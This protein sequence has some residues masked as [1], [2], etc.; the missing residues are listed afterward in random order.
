MKHKICFITLFIVLSFGNIIQAQ[1]TEQKSISCP[2]S[3]DGSLAVFPSFGTAPYTYVWSTGSTENIIKGLGPGVYSVTVTD[4]LAVSNNYS[5][6]LSDPPAITAAYAIVPNSNWPTPNGRITINASGGSGWFTYQLIDSTTTEETTQTNNVFNNRFSGTYFVTITDV[7]GCERYDTV[8]VTETAGITTTF[9]I[10]YTACYRSTAP[11]SNVI[12]VLVPANLPTQVQFPEDTVTIVELLS[13]ARYRT[14]TSDTVTSFSYNAQ[15]GRNLFKVVT[16]DNKGFRYSWVVLE[17]SNPITLTFDEPRHVLC[18]GDNSGFIHG[19]NAQGSY[20]DFSYST[21]G[22]S[23]FSSTNQNLNNLY[24]GLYLVTTTDSSGDCSITLPVTILQSDAPLQGT[25]IKKD[26]TCYQSGNGSITG[27]FTGGTGQL[28]YLW[29]SGQTTSSIGGLTAGTYTLTVTDENGCTLTPPAVTINEPLELTVNGFIQQVSCYGYNNGRIQTTPIGGNGGYVYT[30][31][32]DGVLINYND[33]IIS[34]LSPGVYDLHLEDSLGCDYYNSWTVTQ[35]SNFQFEFVNTLISCNDELGTIRVHN[36]EAFPLDVTVEGITQTVV[37]DDTTGFSD[38]PIGDHL[39][40]I[41]NG[42]CTFDT[43]ITFTQPLPLVI[44][45]NP[46]PSLCYDGRGSVE[47]NV[48]GGTSGPNSTLVLD[49]TNYLNIDTTVTILTPANNFI[50][51]RLKAGSYD[52]TVTDD[53][54]CIVNDKVII[55]QPDRPRTFFSVEKTTCPE[56]EDGKALVT[57]VIPFQDPCT[58]LWNTTPIQTTQE[59]DSLA[60]GWYKVQVTDFNNCVVTD[61]VEVEAGNGVAI[62]NTITQNGDGLNDVIDVRNLCYNASSV[63]FVIQNRDNLTLFETTDPSEAIWNG[64]D[65]SGNVFSST[66]LV[67]L[68]LK[69]IRQDGSKREYWKTIT[70]IV[71]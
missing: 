28:S 20:G 8:I 41:T 62:P 25:L 11:I 54:G 7:N 4:A 2:G 17:P 15:P 14:S 36:L 6:T 64:R 50:I 42:T 1:I 34:N 58:Y 61:S 70:I 21:S 52:I 63:V 67:F 19:I 56:C 46:T 5:Y 57:Y 13:G 39:V 22:P 31:E 29:D 27:N 32:H 44:S 38:L 66:S 68:Y 43:T 60:T 59:A 45:V 47:V 35:P 30:W 24:S 23:G 53:N 49:G 51:D 26:L 65:K 18:Y 9:D 37:F 71:K 69:I 12:P 48:S 10:D 40:S 33:A 55:Q 16:N 3:K